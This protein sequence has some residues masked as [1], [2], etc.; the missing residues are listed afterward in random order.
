MPTSISEKLID[1]AESGILD[2]ETIAREALQV[3]SE[4]DIED[5]AN[6]AGWLDDIEEED[7]EDD[8]E[9]DSCSLTMSINSSLM[10]H[11]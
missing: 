11:G 2:W 10:L 1:L 3:M 6:G 9:N 8:E 4:D 7:V 5:M